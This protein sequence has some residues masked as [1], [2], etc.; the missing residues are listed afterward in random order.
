[1]WGLSTFRGVSP[2]IGGK[3]LT[4]LGQNLQ[5]SGQLKR[6]LNCACFLLRWLI[7]L[8]APPGRGDGGGPNS[9]CCLMLSAALATLVVMIH[10]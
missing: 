4:E 10:V 2:E 3:A 6:L 8:G 1:M 5:N 9:V 7:D